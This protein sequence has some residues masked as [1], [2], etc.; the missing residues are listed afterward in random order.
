MNRFPHIPVS[1]RTEITCHNHIDPAAHPDQKTGE[2][3]NKNGS[4]PDSAK[5]PRTGKLAD[6]GNIGHIKKN[7]QKVRQYQRQ[8]KQD[9]LTK[10][11]PFRQFHFFSGKHAC[12][13]QSVTAVY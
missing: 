11:R 3:R 5:S 10:K 9:N 13:F 8:R 12:T 2:E 4:G 1:S 7:L 6:H